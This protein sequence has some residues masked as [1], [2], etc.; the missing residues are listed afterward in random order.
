MKHILLTTI[1]AVLLVGC[2]TTQP[3]EP[4][5]AK[6]P[7]MSIQDAA[8]YGSI[9]A[10]KEHLVQLQELGYIHSQEEIKVDYGEGEYKEVEMADGSKLLLKKLDSK[11]HDIRNRSMALQSLHESNSKGEILTGLFYLDSQKPN[12]QKIMNLSEQPLIHLDEK[13]ARM[14]ESEFT[15][16]LNKYR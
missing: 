9:K 7:D 10:V 11:N 2:G 12:L 15:K 13:T 3:T 6:A 8:L 5:A 1:A 4:L 14:N 16:V